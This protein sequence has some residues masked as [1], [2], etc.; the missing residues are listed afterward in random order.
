[1]GTW[2]MRRVK[3]GVKFSDDWGKKAYKTKVPMEDRCFVLIGEDAVLAFECP[4]EVT[5]NK[6]IKALEALKLHNK[7]HKKLATDWVN[8]GVYKGYTSR[9]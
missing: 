5:R 3:G 4:T 2:R 8:E 6:W 1:M 7:E 9:V